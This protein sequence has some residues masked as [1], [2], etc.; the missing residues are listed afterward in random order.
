MAIL[1]PR[2]DSYM[3][4]LK[5][6]CE[7]D[8]IILDDKQFIEFRSK[9]YH[10][11]YEFISRAKDISKKLLDHY[12][13]F[14]NDKDAILSVGAFDNNE[15]DLNRIE[16]STEMYKFKM[17]LYVDFNISKRKAKEIFKKTSE[18]LWLQI[19]A[20]YEDFHGKN[21]DY[22][23]EYPLTK[24]GKKVDVARLFDLWDKS[25]LVFDLFEKQEVKNYAAISRELGWFH[26][27]DRHHCSDEV[28]NYVEYAKRL[29][30]AA[31]N[32]ELYNEACRPMTFGKKRK[33]KADPQ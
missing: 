29:I 27:V 24:N 11:Q 2:E 15:F 18:D 10:Y 25:L 6:M 20:M 19:E 7:E 1:K 3:V 13:S 23:S 9:F 26:A 32:S 28:K 5:E 12:E 21:T 22:I 30:E 16:I 4:E 33:K 17:D 8:V 31:S 14:K